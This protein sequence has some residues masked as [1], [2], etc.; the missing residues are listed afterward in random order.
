[1]RIAKEETLYEYVGSENRGFTSPYRD[2]IH[3][4]TTVSPSTSMQDCKYIP[5][6]L[7]LLIGQVYIKPASVVLCLTAIVPPSRPTAPLRAPFLQSG[8]VHEEGTASCEDYEGPSITIP[9]D[10][11]TP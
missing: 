10:L 4:R 11:S 3:N 2:N 8:S 1:M 6:N 7:L 5:T 9:R